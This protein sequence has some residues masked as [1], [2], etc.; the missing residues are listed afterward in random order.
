[1]D[2]NFKMFADNKIT[3]IAILNNLQT[4]A[5]LLVFIQNSI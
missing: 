5:L 2:I 1:V 3:W 4:S